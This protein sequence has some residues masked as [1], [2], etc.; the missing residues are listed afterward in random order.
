MP[1]V[2][3]HRGSKKIWPCR[4]RE[5]LRLGFTGGELA[6]TDPQGPAGTAGTGSYGRSLLCLDTTLVMPGASCPRTAVEE[7]AHGRLFQLLFGCLLLLHPLSWGHAF[8][9][10]TQH[11][12]PLGGPSC[13]M[14]KCEADTL[15]FFLM[16][17]L[18][19]R[20][21]LLWW[22]WAVG[23]AWFSLLLPP[24]QCHFK[25]RQG[26]SRETEFVMTTLGQ[27]W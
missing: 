25:F 3:I 1:L 21:E 16:V 23:L 11:Q 7:S 27:F 22:W 2:I 9:G 18:R 5:C 14:V 20:A 10:T 19:P 26:N 4:A 6:S 17:A 24:L 8:M 13:P 15:R 12:L